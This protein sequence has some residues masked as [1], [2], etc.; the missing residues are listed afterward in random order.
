MTKKRRRGLSIK[1]VSAIY[2]AAVIVVLTIITVVVGYRLYEEH[3]MD[4]YS[5][6][7]TTVL[8]LAHSVANEFSFGDMIADRDM[9]EAYEEMRDRLNSVK[10]SSEIDYLYAVYFDDI[11]DMHS[12]KYAINAKTAEEMKTAENI[13]ISVHPVKREAFRMK[14]CSSFRMP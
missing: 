14:L 8:D 6:Y 5:K 4:H 3:V 13:L 7:T 2:S 9:P 11:N 10:E 12:L 1:I